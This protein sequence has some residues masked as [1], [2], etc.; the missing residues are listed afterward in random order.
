MIER[1][2]AANR[3]YISR[4][5]ASQGRQAT[6]DVSLSVSPIPPAA[7][8]IIGISQTARDITESKQT[9]QALEPGNR[10]AAAAFEDLQ[11]P[12]PG[13]GHRGQFRP[14]QRRA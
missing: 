4:L 8:K 11:R 9:R 2:A 10:G 7:G 14:G 5:R 12:H 6:V 1:A 3:S 13:H